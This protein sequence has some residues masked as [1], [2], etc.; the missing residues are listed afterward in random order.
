VTEVIPAKEPEV[1]PALAEKI[2]AKVSAPIIEEEKA[3]PVFE[4]SQISP[5]EKTFSDESDIE[6]Q[7]KFSKL[8]DS[9]QAT[10]ETKRVVKK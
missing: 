2:A 1:I 3:N 10:Q 8:A 7:H 6:V 9:V 4:L 5:V